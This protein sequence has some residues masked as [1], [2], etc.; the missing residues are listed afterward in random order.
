MIPAVAWKGP[1]IAPRESSF[2]LSF[3][4]N[5]RDPGLHSRAADGAS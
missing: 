5:S 2:G 1:K 3:L 4:I